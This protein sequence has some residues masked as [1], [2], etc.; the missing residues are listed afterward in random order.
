MEALVPLREQVLAALGLLREQQG[1]RF[2]GFADCSVEQIAGL[3]GLSPE[4]AALAATREYSEPLVWED[5]EERKA[6]FLAALEHHQLRGLQGGRFLSVAGQTDKGRA[7]N[8]L[9][10]RFSSQPTVIA[11]GDSPNDED[12]LAAADIAVIIRSE[13]SD[14]IQPTGPRRIVRTEQPGPQGWHEAMMP[15]LSEYQ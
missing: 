8:R 6:E 5:S 4:H 10:D 12:M 2:T 9:R 7:L 15:L 1:F 11:L 13:R 3:T 14:G